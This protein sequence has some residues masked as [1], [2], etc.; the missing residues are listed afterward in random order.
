MLSILSFG[1]N[2]CIMYNIPTTELYT[3]KSAFETCFG[4]LPKSLLDFVFGKD[5][6]KCG[7]VDADKAQKFIQQIQLIHQAM[8]EQLESSQVKYKERHEKHRVDHHFQIGD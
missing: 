1:M 5:T 4:Y 3:Q 7:Q 2:S 6:V 8:Q